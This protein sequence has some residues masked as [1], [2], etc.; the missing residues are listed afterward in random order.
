MKTEELLDDENLKA[1]LQQDVPNFNP[2]IE[3]YLTRIKS[4]LKI[5]IESFSKIPGV[6]A[7]LNSSEDPEC[8]IDIDIAGS[9]RAF[10]HGSYK[11]TISFV[12]K[13]DGT[14]SY[15]FTNGELDE[16]CTAWKTK[17]ENV[18]ANTWKALYDSIILLITNYRNAI[19]DFEE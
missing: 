13:V 10:M 15:Y 17:L 4:M 1:L 5:W 12:L 2:E 18:S 16:I 8:L 6:F 11:P 7:Q 3:E 19:P 14:Y 9:L